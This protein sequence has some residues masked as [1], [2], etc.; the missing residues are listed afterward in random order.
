M[1]KLTNREYRNIAKRPAEGRGFGFSAR[2]PVESP[3]LEEV[4]RETEEELREAREAR[5]CGICDD[6][7]ECPDK[8]EVPKVRKAPKKK[9][10][11]KKAKK[12]GKKFEQPQSLGS[13]DGARSVKETQ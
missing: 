9:V 8:V 12:F 13:V 5:E 3:T 7:P 2:R 11:A 6:L 4:L 1:S 10:K